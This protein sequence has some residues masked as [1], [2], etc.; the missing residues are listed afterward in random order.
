VRARFAVEF[1]VPDTWEHVGIFGIP[2]EDKTHGWYYPNRPG[3]RG[4]AWIDASELFVAQKFGWH[5][6][7]LEGI[8]FTTE[9]KAQRKRFEPGADEATRRLVNA[10]PLDTWANR[11]SEAREVVDNRPDLHPA[12]AKAISAALRAIVIQSIG[13]FA[14]RGRS[15][16][17]I[18]YDPITI[19]STTPA[20][21]LGKAHVYP[22]PQKHNP[23]QQA[24]Y[25]PEFAVQV[26]GRGRA[27]VLHHTVRRKGFAPVQTGALTLPG[28][29][30]IGINGDAIYSSVL[31]SWSLPEANGGADDGRAGLLRLQGWLPGPVKTPVLRADR[32]KLRD[33]A[34]KAGYTP[35]VDE[36]VFEH[37]F[38]PPED[39]LFDH[40]VFEEDA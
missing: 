32:D 20:K 11:L 24:F 8:L 29:S 16:T 22:V 9:K 21:T 6:R 17:A 33:R 7:F 38:I 2:F 28:R 25:R 15:A 35:G 18:T 19:P 26:W 5:F 40:D 12:V 23:R 30:I 39:A 4:Q 1:T 31:P 14:S 34:V 27:R 13:A 37:E 10:R 3:A 36:A